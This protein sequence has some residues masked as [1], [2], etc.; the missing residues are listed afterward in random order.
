MKGS[1]IVALASLLLFS[2]MRAQEMI[3]T[4]P[5]AGIRLYKRPFPPGKGDLFIIGMPIV[6]Y[7][8]SNGFQYGVGASASVFLGEPATTG[9][10]SALVSLTYTTKKQ[11]LFFF[12]STIFTDGNGWLLNGD[13]RYMDTSQPTYG[14]GTGPSSSKLASNGF[15]I[16]DEQYSAPVNDAQMMAYKQIR[17]YETVLKKVRSNFYLGLGYHLDIFT[18]VDDQL[19]AL[20]SVPPVITSYYR[21][22]DSTGFDQDRNVLS[23]FSLNASYD[24]RDNQNCP[25]KG[26]YANISFHVNP[27]FLGSDKNSTMLYTEYRKY[28][29]LTKN[30]HNMLCFWGIGN[31]LTSGVMPYNDLPALGED[32]YNK[33]GRGYTVGRFRG[34]DLVYGEVEFR[35]HLAS[36]KKSPDFLGMVVFFNAVTASNSYADI[37][38]FDY[39]NIGGG[40]GIRI[41]AS[42]NARTKLGIDY[43]WGNYGSSGFYLRMNETF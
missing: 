32:Q 18:D 17:F 11:L 1:F 22:N 29:D 43:A 35:K 4:V 20:D 12:K 15:E 30:H 7:N 10:S 13:W 36:T 34:Q 26:Q 40:A 41:M 42:K 25:F 24:S 33:S 31:F 8:P 5:V 16:G 38:L 28:F 39:V 6:A 27:E 3:D 14:G 21:Y 19:L 9:I 23:G 2:P 37:K